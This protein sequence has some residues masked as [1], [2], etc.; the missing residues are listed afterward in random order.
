MDTWRPAKP[1]IR[2]RPVWSLVEPLI[3][4][5]AMTV[6]GTVVLITA[7]CGLVIVTGGIFLLAKGAITLAATSGTDALSIEW[8][9][10]F[11]I[12][13]Q[14]PGVAFFVIG[15][16]F[17]VAALYAARPQRVEPIDVNGEVDGVDGPVTLVV[18][19]QTWQFPALSGGVIRARIYPDVSTLVLEASAPGYEP[20]S[21]AIE[22]SSSTQVS[23]G[24]V[25]LKK[26]LQ[27]IQAKG[28]NISPIG[29]PAPRVTDTAQAFGAP[30]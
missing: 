27:E 5:G 25:Q 6:F 12:N 23:I 21:M 28:E 9:K 30:R 19:P 29:F 10:Q 3:S 2:L 11:K 16:C 7:L 24:R 14:V 22:V 13:T 20:T 8:Q 15:L 17:I 26:R 1:S 18:K 4:D